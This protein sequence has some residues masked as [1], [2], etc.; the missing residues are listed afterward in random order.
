M[1]VTVKN[2]HQMSYEI[3]VDINIPLVDFHKQVC[4]KFG[5]QNARLIYS[6]RIMDLTE[7]LSKYMKETDRGFIVAMKV[8][9]P[10]VNAPLNTPQTS[11]QLYNFNQVRAALVGM[12]RFISTNQLLNYTYFTSQSEFYN[13]MRSDAF[14]DIIHQVLD[15]S[16]EITSTLNENGNMTV[17]IAMPSNTEHNSNPAPTSTPTPTP[18]VAPASTPTPTLAS[19]STPT[20]TLAPALAPAPTPTTN[21]NELTQQDRTNIQTLIGFG[22]SEQ[23]VIITYLMAGKDVN[24]AASLLLD[25]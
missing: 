6:G 11:E 10:Q 24:L 9:T 8:N 14:V 19:T 21:N 22:Y 17:E 3:D 7:N 18:T 15:H 16:N 13:I 5:Y 20:P 25:L 12:L 2:M 23:Q 1:I 4:E